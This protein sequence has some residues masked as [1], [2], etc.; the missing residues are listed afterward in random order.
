MKINKNDNKKISHLIDQLEDDVESVPQNLK[1]SAKDIES[2]VEDIPADAYRNWNKM[3]STKYLVNFFLIGIPY[4]FYCV[5]GVAYNLWFN[6]VWGDW[7]AQ[8]NLWLL[9]N[10]FYIVSQSIFSMIVMF[11]VPFIMKYTKF[12]RFCSLMSAI[13]YNLIYFMMTVDWIY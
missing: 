11:E 9:V 10:T 2:Y 13:G 4:A 1:E 3:M 8:G 5:F 7:W 12:F 6:I